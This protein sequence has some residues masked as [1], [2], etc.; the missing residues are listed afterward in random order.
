V[1]DS[2]ESARDVN[3]VHYTVGAGADLAFNYDREA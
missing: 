1:V 2:A 3:R